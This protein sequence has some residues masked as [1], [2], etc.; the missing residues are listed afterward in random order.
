MSKIRFK[1]T[2]GEQVKYI[3]HLDMM[4]V[5]ERA[6]RRGNLPIAYSQGFNPHP[7]MVFGL[8]LSVGVTSEAEYADF[9]LAA[10]MKPQDFIESYNKVLPKGFIITD[11]N[12]NQGKN[13]I[14]A[15][16]SKASYSILVSS[17]KKDGIDTI[18]K[19]VEEF[20][21]QADIIVRKET[22]SGAKDVDIKPMIHGIQVLIPGACNEKE[23][24]NSSC[25]SP[26]IEEYAQRILDNSVDG[27]CSKS[28]HLFC[29]SALLSAG[30]AANLKP[31]LL[32][33][34]LNQTAD[35]EFN[36]LKIHRTGLYVERDR[37]TF[38]PLDF[39]I[40][41]VV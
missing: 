31:E 19:K 37:R 25:L 41:K 39:E 2:R 22:K 14:M 28:D 5:F 34:A 4:K 30:S 38:D 6:A 7:Q 10:D 23:D 3:S 32:I 24:K 9:D 35:L 20:L 40:L 1:F 26:F 8:P 29:V 15:T 11:A 33:S 13:N 27:Q 17:G 21:S 12:Y 36:V 16:I 18:C